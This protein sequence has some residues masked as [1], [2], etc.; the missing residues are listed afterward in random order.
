AAMQFIINQIPAVFRENIGLSIGFLLVGMLS[1]KS[2]LILYSSLRAVYFEREQ[3][4]LSRERLKLQVKTAAAQL[5]QVE[6]SKALW[7]G[8]R[9]FQIAKK[10]KECHDVYSFYLTPHDGKSLPEF[11]PGQYLTFQLDVPG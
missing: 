11:K 3:R 5:K 9:K 1:A 4:R 6:Q 7:N 10:V 2:F 8:I